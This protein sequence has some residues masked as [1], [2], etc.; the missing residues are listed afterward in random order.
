MLDTKGTSKSVLACSIATAATELR[1]S[2]FARLCQQ[3]H[4]VKVELWANVHHKA[5]ARS[6]CTSSKP[7]AQPNFQHPPVLTYLT[8]SRPPSTFNAKRC[9]DP[10]VSPPS[11]P[12]IKRH[13]GLSLRGGSNITS[14]INKQ[15]GPRATQP[16]RYQYN[17]VQRDSMK[18]SP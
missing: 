3:T 5:L 4:N 16:E 15:F 18:R 10:T 7:S 6:H 14:L 11:T 2:F 9:W 8:L 17:S 13:L 1:Q 12:F